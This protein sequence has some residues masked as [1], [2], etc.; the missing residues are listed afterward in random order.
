MRVIAA[1][2]QPSIVGR[3]IRVPFEKLENVPLKAR[4][5]KDN[6]PHWYQQPAAKP[7][8]D[9]LVNS[10][11]SQVKPQNR[12]KLQPYFDRVSNAKNADDQ[13]LAVRDLIDQLDQANE[14]DARDRVWEILDEIRGDEA[15][16][17]LKKVQDAPE[18]PAGEETVETPDELPG[19]PERG[20]QPPAPEPEAAPAP[21]PE[22]APEPVAETPTPEPTPVQQEI[23]DRGG[24]RSGNDPESMTSEEL[25]AA[26]QAEMRRFL[27]KEISIDEMNERIKPFADELDRRQ[28]EEDRTQ[29]EGETSFPEPE[30]MTPE[31]DAVP[32]ADIMDRVAEDIAAPAPPAEPPA[33]FIPD[34]QGEER[35][36][37]RTQK[38]RRG[39][40]DTRLE[41]R[42]GIDPNG[43]LIQAGVLVDVA[44]GRKRNARPGE[45]VREAFQGGVVRI[46]PDGRVV[47][48]DFG[49]KY[50]DKPGNAERKVPY[51]DFKI[52]QE[53]VNVLDIG[54]D[55]AAILEQLNEKAGKE[56]GRQFADKGVGRIAPVIGGNI[57]I[58]PGWVGPAPAI[59]ERRVVGVDG[60]LVQKGDWV[61][62]PDGRVGYVSRI[63]TPWDNNYNPRV[64]VR[65]PGGGKDDPD[66]KNRIV[67]LN[68][69]LVQ[70]LA[71]P[72]QDIFAN[73]NDKDKDNKGVFAL[74]P[75]E[76][77]ELARKYGMSDALANA[78]AAGDANAARAEFENDPKANEFFKK[79]IAKRDDFF[80]RVGEGKASPS[81]VKEYQEIW[82]EAVSLRAALY[83]QFAKP[84]ADPDRRNALPQ[85]IQELAGTTPTTPDGP[86]AD[87]PGTPTPDAPPAPEAP[88]APEP[89][90]ATP[91]PTENQHD[92]D[93]LKK[94]AQRQGGLMRAVL[95]ARD[96]ARQRQPQRAQAFDEVAKVL[97][98][99]GKIGIS[100]PDQF[101]DLIVDAR[102]RVGLLDLKL[103]K[104]MEEYRKDY[105]QYMADFNA[106]RFNPEAPEAP[107][108][109]EAPATPDAPDYYVDV[110][111]LND[112]DVLET[113]LL[114]DPALPDGERPGLYRDTVRDANGESE[115]IIKD[116][117]GNIL[118][119]FTGTDDDVAADVNSWIDSDL[120]NEE[121]AATPE[122]PSV[123]LPEGWSVEGPPEAPVYV[124]T[125]TE[126]KVTTRVFENF[127]D[128]NSD[129]WSY[130]VR[131]ENGDLIA[132]GRGRSSAEQAIADA[133]IAKADA[134]K[135][136]VPGTPEATPL[137]DADQ[138]SPGAAENQQIGNVLDAVGAV[139]SPDESKK[140]TTRQQK[141]INDLAKRSILDNADI[142]DGDKALLQYWLDK[143]N[144]GELSRA[145]ASKLIDALI[146][147]DDNIKAE[148]VVEENKRPL[149]PSIDL[150]ELPIPGQGARKPVVMDVDDSNVL[151][152][153]K[154]DGNYRGVNARLRAV[155]NEVGDASL[156]LKDSDPDL[157]YRVREFAKSLGFA[158]DGK[159]RDKDDLIRQAGRSLMSAIAYGWDDGI[160]YLGDIS[161]AVNRKQE[162]PRP[163]F[164]ADQ[165]NSY[166]E[167]VKLFREV[168][169][170]SRRDNPDRNQRA[171]AQVMG[172]RM[173]DLAGIGHPNIGPF[174]SAHA[175]VQS[176]LDNDS[177]MQSLSSIPDLKTRIQEALN[178]FSPEWQNFK[179]KY[180]NFP[181]REERNAAI[182]RD[183]RG[184]RVND[185]EKNIA[186]AGW[187]FLKNDFSRG[188]NGA[189]TYNGVAILQDAAGH[190]I[191]LKYDGDRGD[192]AGN[193]KEGKGVNA[194]LDIAQLYRAFGL[195]QPEALRINPDSNGSEERDL[196]FMDFG[197]EEFGLTDLKEIANVGWNGPSLGEMAKPEEILQFVASNAV[198]MNSD[199]HGGNIMLARDGAGQYE[200]V[201]IDNGLA[202]KNSAFGQIGYY[203]KSHDVSELP[204][205][206]QVTQG[207]VVNTRKHFM[208]RGG[209]LLEQYLA[210]VGR[211]QA[212]EELTQ[213]AEK[214]RREAEQRKNQLHDK[215]H[216]AFVLQ[217]IDWL[218]NN[219]EEYIDGLMP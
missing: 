179:G 86:A 80:R 29:V 176:A 186:P 4:I 199:R 116:G 146:R 187:T 122:A 142:S 172:R 117:Q 60:H 210:R 216:A 55:R 99:A 41:A 114:G 98:Q 94:L 73:R 47:V 2:N 48:R 207:R 139:V 52:K 168:A 91:A 200:I 198:M 82:G 30:P 165:L 71:D 157:Y 170:L 37:G 149:P 133:E 163:D 153:L 159:S 21:E 155:A 185:L 87:T 57:K 205:P 192:V 166:R 215:D 19:A 141:Y 208:A 49:E 211:D 150:D 109:L 53:D 74:T 173:M 1:P 70:Y 32:I 171:N 84:D 175:Q 130:D 78:L 174:P 107:A 88:A 180:G 31:P 14:P 44:P 68:G 75:E 212:V 178:G 124:K 39:I 101:N 191:V 35:V 143:A 160:R 28:P 219:A 112:L 108:A 181:S 161:A 115:W 110:S 151:E 46:Q 96:A 196:F 183:L 203:L 202:L 111:D 9:R 118:A 10:A 140:V 177:L 135:V 190:K 137:P 59:A 85:T 23:I 54:L 144:N 218:A 189:P 127:I 214:M 18:R 13:F 147:A 72:D 106:G 50:R 76:A 119:R 65:V 43:N 12:S 148:K 104:G 22:P 213:W 97:D 3:R 123:N 193:D 197:G 128:G 81:A 113:V 27:N 34:I 184:L 102:N 164:N 169:I 67:E 156:E 5:G 90:A 42:V 129:G 134:E 64:L 154:P 201:P 25:S 132:G 16:A 100:D 125:D 38:V 182:V 62:L 92:E 162:L 77:G 131:D 158:A 105:L 83:G 120:R 61:K 63:N 26:I 7:Y 194:E 103:R 58:P 138:P 95:Q 36:R 136:G 188:R 66:K 20:E 17:N 15:K 6:R 126:K 33:G 152:N 8:V 206:L 93:R 89:E 209:G 24:E 217:R 45:V 11:R 51:Y 204:T 195:K 56:A 40:E 121:S 69:S 79:A 145:H 167:F